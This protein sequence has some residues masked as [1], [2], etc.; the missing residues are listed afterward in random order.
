[1]TVLSSYLLVILCM[2]LTIYNY[3]ILDDVLIKAFLHAYLES[4]KHFSPGATTYLNPALMII[5]VGNV[6]LRI[7]GPLGSWKKNEIT[8]RL[9]CMLWNPK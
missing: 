5:D 6:W 8:W 4:Q 9:I 3:N 2:F 1:V 7:D